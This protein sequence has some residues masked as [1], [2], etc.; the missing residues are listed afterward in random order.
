MICIT[1]AI[2]IASVSCAFFGFIFFFFV[3]QPPCVVQIALAI[4]VV[5]VDP[6]YVFAAYGCISFFYF[7]LLESFEFEFNKDVIVATMLVI[8][9]GVIIVVSMTTFEFEFNKNVI[10]ATMPVIAIGVI[11]VSM[12]ISILQ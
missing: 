5:V 7:F 8:A 9:I 12:M 3:Q 4:D 11:I 10:V 1:I 2:A 6:C